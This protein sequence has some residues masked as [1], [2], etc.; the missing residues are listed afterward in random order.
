MK[1]LK[2]ILAFL[3]RPNKI[4]LCAL[5]AAT[6][7]LG[8]ASAAAIVLGMRGAGSIALFAC[9][10]VAFA[11]SAC[12]AV[13]GVRALGAKIAGRAKKHPF[14]NS[15]L[16]DYGFRTLVF[17]LFSFVVNVAF[18]LF[19]G[20]LGIATRSAWYGIFA[21][22]YLALSALRGGMLAGNARLK[23][24]AQGGA[25]RAG[26]LKLYRAC[27]LSLLAL[28]LAL[29]AAVSLMILSDRPTAYSEVM[30]IASAA[31]T[32]YK[33]AL[34][35]VN[36]RRARRLRDP[37]LQSFRSINLTDAAVSLLSLQVTL[38]AVFSADNA[39]EMNALNAVTG[40]A[41]CALTIFTGTAMVVRASV[42]LKRMRLSA[43]CARGDAGAK[44][45]GGAG[46]KEGEACAAQRQARISSAGDDAQQ[47]AR[48]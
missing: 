22:Y 33:V 39:A 13:R 37:V 10:G 20:V 17:F 26:K 42:Q 7:C 43:A 48:S 18:A 40:F 9:T 12:T 23:R 8:A 44:G 24:R 47:S 25:L 21:C 1:T 19:N 45:S 32:F 16:T 29:A 31:Y 3:K 38:V 34:A 15:L 2:G 6:L 4:F 11:W 36:A 46:G 14:A 28:E 30:A 27:G 5:W 35:I 41:V